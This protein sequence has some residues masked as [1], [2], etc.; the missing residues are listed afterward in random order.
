MLERVENI[1]KR[2]EMVTLQQAR[3]TAAQSPLFAALGP[4]RPLSPSLAPP[5]PSSPSSP[6]DSPSS[7]SRAQSPAH[8]PAQSPARSPTQTEVEERREMQARALRLRDRLDVTRRTS[9]DEAGLAALWEIA[10]EANQLVDR[11]QNSAKRLAISSIRSHRRQE[12]GSTMMTRT[13]SSPRNFSR[14]ASVLSVLSM[15]ST[16]A[17]PSPSIFDSR[18]SPQSVKTNIT[19]PSPTLTSGLGADW[20]LPRAA[21]TSVASRKPVKL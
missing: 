1:H 4:S 5:S 21:L 2:S 12:V 13:P 8:S 19:V 9:H 10:A 20:P 15:S 6:L 17:T 7:R 11:S 3:Q 14:P 18:G 16:S